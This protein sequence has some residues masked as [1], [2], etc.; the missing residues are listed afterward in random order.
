MRLVGCDI[1]SNFG[2]EVLVE[3]Y[4]ESDDFR[5]LAVGF[6]M[7]TAARLEPALVTGDGRQTVAGLITELNRDPAR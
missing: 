5:L 3:K 7:V 2:D 4:G 6:H 1:S